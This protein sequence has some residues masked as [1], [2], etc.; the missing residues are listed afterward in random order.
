M[1]RTR[2]TWDQ[3]IP[4]D[5]TNQAVRYLLD[6][7]KL[8]GRTNK[9]EILYSKGEPK[10]TEFLSA[11]LNLLQTNSGLTGFWNNETQGLILNT[12]T[13]NKRKR[14][15][16]DITYQSNVGRRLDLVFE[17]KKVSRSSLSTYRGNN[18]MRRFVDGH[19]AER[20]PLAI[21]VGIINGSCTDVIDSLY[22]SLS[23]PTAARGDLHMD[24]DSQGRYVRKPSNVLPEFAKFDTEHNRPP[25]QSPQN[26]TTTLAH[27]F[28]HCP[29]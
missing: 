27:T 3:L 1:G 13:Q 9:E 18:G 14:V 11:Q 16:K 8:I 12:V 20:C 29:D 26:G 22:R 10:L 28:V 17:F 21:M 4:V 19:Y 25:E 23:I 24:H 2:Y 15:K 6:T 5:E 7:W